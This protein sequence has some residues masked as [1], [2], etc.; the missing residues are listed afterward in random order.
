MEFLQNKWNICKINRIFAF[1]V[2]WHPIKFWQTA[3]FEGHSTLSSGSDNLNSQERPEFS[4]DFMFWSF[5][6]PHSD[7]W[8][9]NWSEYWMWNP[10]PNLAQHRQLNCQSGRPWE[11]F[12]GFWE[13][14]NIISSCICSMKIIKSPALQNCAIISFTIWLKVP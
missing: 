2:I 6:Q 11:R 9:S 5:I 7:F 4:L 12:L 10:H 13:E 1:V 14:K 3:S 8:E